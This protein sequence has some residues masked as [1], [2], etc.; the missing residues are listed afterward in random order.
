M[1][2]CYFLSPGLIGME[3]AL[4]VFLY[5]MIAGTLKRFRTAALARRMSAR[6]A[7]EGSTILESA[8]LAELT[9]VGSAL[10]ISPPAGPWQGPTYF[11]D[12]YADLLG[13]FRTEVLARGKT[14]AGKEKATAGLAGIATGEALNGVLE[15]VILV[16]N[17]IA[18]FGYLIFPV[19]FLGTKDQVRMGV[20]VGDHL[21][22]SH[23]NEPSL[24]TCLFTAQVAALVPFWFASDVATAEWNGNFAGDFAWTVNHLALVPIQLSSHAF[25]GVSEIFS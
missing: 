2:M 15:L 1:Y 8:T 4:V 21:R 7:K 22:V 6:L 13:T 17:V 12:A 5:W 16:L 19:T 10:E 20:A 25:P 24:L 14:A 23:T 11:V 9:V 3:V 18:W